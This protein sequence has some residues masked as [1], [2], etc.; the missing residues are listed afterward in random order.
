MPS[1][2]VPWNVYTTAL[3]R[4][5]QMLALTTDLSSWP[6]T[7][8]GTPRLPPA[9]CVLPGTHKFTQVSPIALTEPLKATC[10][11]SD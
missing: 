10:Q 6:H 11:Q 3:Q 1:S 4:K 7:A 5:R 9:N 8:G 2:N